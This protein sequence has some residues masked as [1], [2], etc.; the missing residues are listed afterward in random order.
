[1][2]TAL[3]RPPAIAPAFVAS[4]VIHVAVGVALFGLI[5][6]GRQGPGEPFAPLAVRLV[7]PP[8]PAEAP[9]AP[10]APE[11]VVT[12]DASAVALP[13][14]SAEASAE[15]RPAQVADEARA[16]AQRP[17]PASAPAPP[18][19]AVRVRENYGAMGGIS[20]DIVTRAQSDYLIEVEKPVR[21]LQMPEVPYPPEALRAGRQDTVVAWV[22]IDREG[23]IE[24][25]VIDS[26]EPEFAEAV[27][28]ALPTAKFLPAEERGEIVPFYIVLQFDF[29]MAG[30]TSGVA[31][32]VAPAPAT[33]AQPGQ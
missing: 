24:D 16:E 1:M 17:T 3:R 12:A 20:A 8:A 6:T 33:A 4:L 15:P 13:A 21:V 28:A 14:P 22:A 32:G 30:G 18:P 5:A 29:R 27:R 19:G 25:V 11:V 26:G 23:A 9:P 7:G 31:A 10:A 2:T